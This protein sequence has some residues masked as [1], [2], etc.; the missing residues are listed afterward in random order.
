MKYDATN[1]KP[2]CTAIYINHY[3]SLF[4]EDMLFCRFYLMIE[5]TYPVAHKAA[6]VVIPVFFVLGS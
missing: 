1:Q 3:N 4:K 2:T 5:H 6:P